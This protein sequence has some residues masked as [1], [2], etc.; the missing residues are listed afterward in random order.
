M[1][2]T[3]ALRFRDLAGPTI[4]GH[5][6]RITETGS[7]W[8]AWWSKPE[9]KI[10]RELLAEL[11]GRIEQDEE[12]WLFLVDSGH[13]QVYRAKLQD[14]AVA[15][16]TSRIPSPDVERTPAYYEDQD[17][18][19]WF[20]FSAIEDPDPQQPDQQL[21]NYSYDE[22]PE[23]AFDADP[24]REDFNGKRVFDVAE[25]LGRHRTMYFLRPAAEGDPAHK[26]TLGASERTAPFMRS[27]IEVPS[28]YV[29][30]LSDLHFGAHHAFH[31]TTD[32]PNRNLAIRVIDDLKSRYGDKPPAAVILSGDFTWLGASNEFDQ[33]ATL[34]DELQSVYKLHPARFVICPGNHD[35]QWAE[36]AAGDEY[37]PK[38]PVARAKPQAEANYR[39]F[40]AK[41]L[42]LTFPAESLA[43]GRRYLLSNFM[44]LDI[45]AV[46]SSQL[47]NRHFAG[48]GFV[49]REQLIAAADAMGWT[50]SPETGPKLRVLVLHHH[51]VPVVPQEEMFNPEERYSL[52][53][54]AAQLLYTALEYGVDLIV[55]GHQHQPL[56]ASYGRVD[57]PGVIAPTRRLAIQAA[58]SAGVKADDIPHNFGRNSYCVYEIGER[59]VRVVIRATS[60]DVSGFTDYWDYALDRDSRNG[61]SPA[62]APAA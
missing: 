39:E 19:V 8:W 60:E 6:E 56:A 31:L 17:Y 34:V 2:T 28:D 9:E 1:P 32:P 42:Q 29:L 10:P 27:S 5:L 61:L 20:E 50:A 57:R 45:V 38:A 4:P 30:H 22:L 54:D 43:M 48:Y 3:I 14:L 37:A 13:R 33:A 24:Y 23:G 62:P 58:G 35:I 11:K 7:A 49:G 52:T 21:T 55:H 15:P 59:T 16:G 12:V 44:P 40:A 51:V 46:N 25:L 36:L 41:S 26:V 47:E 18:L 53:L